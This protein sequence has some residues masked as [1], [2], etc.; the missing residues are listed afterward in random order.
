[1]ISYDDLQYVWE[2]LLEAYRRCCFPDKLSRY[3]S[4]YLFGNQNN[5]IEFQET[6]HPY[7]VNLTA[8]KC[9]LH[10]TQRIE[11]HD[12]KW[13]NDIPTD[14][15]FETY[16]GYADKYWSGVMSPNPIVEFLFSG[17]YKLSAVQSKNQ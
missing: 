4:I 8:C 5:M 13:I 14:C 11:A 3:S 1:M 10:E 7:D 16:K 6:H 2:Y 15:T 12:M 9:L 17:V